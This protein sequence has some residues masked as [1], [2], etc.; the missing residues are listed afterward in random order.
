MFKEGLEF[1]LSHFDHQGFWPKTIS[2]ALTNGAQ[3]TD[4]DRYYALA[5]FKQSNLIDYRINAYPSH[6]KEYKG[7]TWQIPD[8]I[9]IDYDLE[10]FFPF[11]NWSSKQ[12]L[13]IAKDYTLWKIK[14]VFGKDI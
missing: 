14:Q 10:N 8:F 6:S 9:F 2:T 12:L 7:V 5:K 1:I 3:I 11:G 4:Y 13:G